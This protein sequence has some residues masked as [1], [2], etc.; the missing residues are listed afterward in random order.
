VTRHLDWMDSPWLFFQ[1]CWVVVKD[2]VMAVFFEFLRRRQLVKSL[3]LTFVSLVLK[4]VDAIEIKDFRPISL[5]GG[6]HKIL[7]KVLANRMKTV[8]GK[9]ISNSQN[10]FIGGCQI[11][12][13]VLIANE[14]LDA[15]M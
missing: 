9:I 6:M 15:R 2:D 5:V 8:L 1:A 13:Y 7:S 4:K 11:L 14:C 3:N 12:D 10:S